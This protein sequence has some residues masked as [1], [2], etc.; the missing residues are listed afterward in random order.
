VKGIREVQARVLAASF[1]EAVG[2]WRETEEG[3]VDCIRGPD[4]SD[5]AARGRIRVNAFAAAGRR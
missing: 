5:C 3:G 4:H 1:R 2:D